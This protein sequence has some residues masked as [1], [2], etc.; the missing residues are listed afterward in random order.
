MNLGEYRCLHPVGVV[1]HCEDRREDGGENCRHG[2][3]EGAPSSMRP[4]F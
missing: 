1:E 3:F 2:F 4:P